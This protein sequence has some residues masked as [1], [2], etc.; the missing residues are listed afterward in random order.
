MPFLR[1]RTSYAMVA[2][3][4]AAMASA[5][6]SWAVSLCWPRRPRSWTQAQLAPKG[7]ESLTD[8]SD[9]LR[10]LTARQS[11]PPCMH[12]V[13]SLSSGFRRSS[14]TTIMWRILV[15]AKRS[16][17]RRGQAIVECQSGHL[18]AP[19]PHSWPASLGNEAPQW[20]RD[21]E[22][23]DELARGADR[24][25]VRSLGR[26]SSSARSWTLHPFPTLWTATALR[27]LAEMPPTDAVVPSKR[28]WYKMRRSE[29][30]DATQLAQAVLQSSHRRQ[31]RYATP[32]ATS[33]PASSLQGSAFRW[34]VLHLRCRVCQE[35]APCR[36]VVDDGASMVLTGNSV[37]S[38]S[39][40]PYAATEA[41]VRLAMLGVVGE[42]EEGA[43]RTPSQCVSSVMPR[44][45]RGPVTLATS[46][47]AWGRCAPRMEAEGHQ[48]LSLARQCDYAPLWCERLGP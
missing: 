31:T 6:M 38:T 26:R 7:S 47:T 40:R 36:C 25:T 16:W 13:S 32:A 35:H 37:S 19:L 23:V 10:G 1:P 12:M 41:P 9:S 44:L 45:T 24:L 3:W 22:A 5:I 46:R 34:R 11:R 17:R 18:S 20:L 29:D 15:L 28:L 42:P 48:C 33:R 43:M 39:C 2:R 21:V 30:K 14:A 4:Y 8:S 27:F